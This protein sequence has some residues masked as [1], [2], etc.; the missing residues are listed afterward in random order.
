MTIGDIVLEIYSLT[1]SDSTSYPAATMLRRLNASYEKRVGQI[2]GADGL[3]Q[4][5]DTNYTDFPIATTTVV[6]GQR[7]YKFDIAHLE[8]EKVAILYASTGLYYFLDTF[9]ISNLSAPVETLY[10]QNGIPMAYDKQGTSLVFDIAPDTTKVTAALGLK[11]WFKRTASIFTSA[12]VTT[13]TKVPGFAS[14][15]HMIMAYDAAIPYCMTYKKDRVALFETKAQQIETE[16]LKFYGR[17]E[18][19]RRKRMTMGQILH[20]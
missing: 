19:D 6:N 7:D 4:F 2:M 12:E 10:P 13:G 14:P 5:D 11:V 20:R 18:Q 17:R 8:I 9:D 3:W 15:F 1:D 16:M